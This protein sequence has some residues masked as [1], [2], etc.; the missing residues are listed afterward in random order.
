MEDGVWYAY[1]EL[2]EKTGVPKSTIQ[3][4]LH[5]MLV[6]RAQMVFDHKKDKVN[7]VGQLVGFLR[8]SEDETLFKVGAEKPHDV[9]SGYD[10]SLLAAS[11]PKYCPVI[12]EEEECVL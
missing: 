3:N 6:G 1:D 8:V 7:G 5:R 12:E 10:A 11:F 4:L 2:A 9:P